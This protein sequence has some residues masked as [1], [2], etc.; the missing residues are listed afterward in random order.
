[1]QKTVSCVTNSVLRPSK[2][3]YK[4]STDPHLLTFPGDPVPLRGEEDLSLSL[5]H[6][7]R[8]RRGIVRGRSKVSTIAYYYELQ[9][10]AEE[11]IISFHWHPGQR[12]SATLP[13]L[14]IGTGAGVKE[15][16]KLWSN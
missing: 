6:Y 5:K 10:R 16:L 4:E 2:E 7:Y 1:M 8:V 14:H 15:K 3:G 9:T 11:E 12:S 13:H